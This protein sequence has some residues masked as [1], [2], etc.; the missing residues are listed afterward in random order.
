MS[1]KFAVFSEN[2][3][4]LTMMIEG[5]HVIPED[6]VLITDVLHKKIINETD[7]VWTLLPD[8][9]ISK[10]PLP[11]VASDYPALIASTR[12]NHEIAGII[13]QG[14]QIDTDRASQ[15]LIT[16]AALSAMLDDEYVCTWKAATGAVLL[17]AVQLIGVATAVRTH[18]QACF[19][20]ECELLAAVADGSF[21][22]AMLTEGWPG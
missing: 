9:S 21:T 20:R 12:F 13:V 17:N 8:G 22:E 2:M 10:E 15:S 7:G 5:V 6:A 3:T 18:V 4:L 19:D 14:T 1:K 11:S 16:G